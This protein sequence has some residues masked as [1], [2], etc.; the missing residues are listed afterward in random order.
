MVNTTVHKGK[1]AITL[2]WTVLYR[3]PCV[4][5][6]R[7]MSAKGMYHKTCGACTEREQARGHNVYG[8]TYRHRG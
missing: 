2:S 8:G 1:C 4:L 3:D 7:D 5:P 6:R